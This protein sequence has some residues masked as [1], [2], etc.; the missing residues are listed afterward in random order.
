MGAVSSF[1]TGGNRHQAREAALSFLYPHD[2]HLGSTTESVEGFLR[3]YQV[4]EA[5]RSYFE[6][7]AQGVLTHLKA[8]DAEIEACAVNW[9]ISRMGK[10]DLAVMRIACFELL[11]CPEIDQK[12]LLDEAVE[13]AKT[14]GSQESAAFVNGVLD[15]IAQK[16]RA[17]A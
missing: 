11:Y 16:V 3:Y 6:K 8:I 9:K 12:I 1:T 5:Y 4:Q 10:V 14:Y 17:A 13:L 2:L 7:L 15:R